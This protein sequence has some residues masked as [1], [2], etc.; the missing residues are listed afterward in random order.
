MPQNKLIKCPRA[1]LLKFVR[2]ENLEWYP[3]ALCFKDINEVGV[4][5]NLFHADYSMPA[6]AIVECRPTAEKRCKSSS[7]IRDFLRK[8][9]FFFIHQK[10]HVEA[11]QFDE[12][13]E[14]GKR[15]PTSTSQVSIDYG[16]INVQEPG[17]FQIREL[18]LGI[19][20]LTVQDDPL[21]LSKVVET[22]FL[23]VFSHR[24][25]IDTQ[26][27][28][29]FDDGEPRRRVL[30][31]FSLALGQEGTHYE[32]TIKQVINVASATGGLA[33]VI[34]PFLAVLSWILCQ[35]LRDLHLAHSYQ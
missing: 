9:P 14:R 10:T 18:T 30:K 28:L 1:Q 17:N 25:L 3:N 35:P 29:R 23:N 26:G 21:G 33:K 15:L 2:E 7:E 11:D 32:R 20:K 6:I 31:M 34:L 22:K 13:D 19:N 12:E 24:S 4:H 16:P 27:S 5:G 8:Y